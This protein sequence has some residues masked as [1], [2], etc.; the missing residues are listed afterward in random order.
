MLERETLKTAI[1]H[2]DAANRLVEAIS[3][4][5]GSLNDR[6]GRAVDAAHGDFAADHDT[7]LAVR[8]RGHARVVDAVGDE[9]QSPC[10]R[11]ADAGLERLLG[12]RPAR[13]VARVVRA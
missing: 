8:F 3:L 2:C 9:Q 12:R 4:D 10:R 5:A 6:R 13:T 11:D 1:I 7:A